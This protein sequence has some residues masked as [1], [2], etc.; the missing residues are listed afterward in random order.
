MAAS[1]SIRE[2]ELQPQ[3]FRGIMQNVRKK[4]LRDQLVLIED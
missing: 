4:I 2:R 3:S 1:L